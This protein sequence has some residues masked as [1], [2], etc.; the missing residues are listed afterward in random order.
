MNPIV[1]L[2][3][4]FLLLK[5][6]LDL[7][8]F[9]NQRLSHLNFRNLNKLILNDLVRRLPVLKFDNDSLYANC[10][11]GKQQQQQRNPI[12]I[13]SKIGELLELPHIDLCGPSTTESI[14]TKK[15]ILVIVDN[16]SHFT[17]V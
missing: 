11:Q 4:I 14:S 15:Y 16:V 9:W 5:A 17:W 7:S 3:S 10:D 1:G 6:S 8:W 2:P 12:F 13:D